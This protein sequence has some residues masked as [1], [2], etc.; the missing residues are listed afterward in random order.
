MLP[1]CLGATARRG[2]FSLARPALSATRA[3]QILAFL[4]QHPRR[5][6][7]LAEIVR[8]TDINVGS[9]FAVLSA[10]TDVGFLSRNEE[11]KSYRLGPALLAAGQ[12][13]FETY[14]IAR[15]AQQCA[16]DL[17]AELDLSVVLTTKVGHEQ[18]VISSV[19]SRSG[20]KFG[21]NAGQRIPLA[22]PLGALLMAWESEEEIERWIGLSATTAEQAQGWRD[23][24]AAIRRRGAQIG[25]RRTAALEYPD[26]LAKLSR[27]G[28]H[29]DHEVRT[30]ELV[31]AYGWDPK[32]LDTLEPDARYQV[33]TISVPVFGERGSTPMCL[34]IGA[35]DGPLTGARIDELVARMIEVSL[36]LNSQVAGT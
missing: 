8:A 19:E 7:T 36:H 5:S 21:V 10:L 3:A 35:F 29:A 31:N 2:N 11:Q 34:G 13:A 30:V 12:A 25:V 15:L 16:I 6:F 24:L 9:C 17:A 1:R 33:S 27:M 20:R 22:P 14:P 32:A 28:A 23:A 4:T 26:L 18:L